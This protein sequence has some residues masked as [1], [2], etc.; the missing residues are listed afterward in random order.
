MSDGLELLKK[1]A[2]ENKS[3]ESEDKEII[4]NT[5]IKNCEDKK[6]NCKIVKNINRKI[7]IIALHDSFPAYVVKNMK[8]EIVDIFVFNNE[9]SSKE[10]ELNKNQTAYLY[11]CDKRLTIKQILL[12]ILAFFVYAF[13]EYI[14]KAMFELSGTILG[15]IPM[16]L[17][18]A[19][20]LGLLFFTV[21]QIKKK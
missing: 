6:G 15:V 14:V 7:K 5:I 2:F 17:I 21:E 3:V 19:T 12:I 10:F 11:C 16:I 8:N 18:T 1:Y 4:A 13:A 9:C 20:M